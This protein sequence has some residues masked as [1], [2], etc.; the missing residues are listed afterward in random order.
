MSVSAKAM[1]A[2]AFTILVWG[3]IPVFLRNLSLSLGPYDFL[4]VRLILAGIILSYVLATTSDFHM[5][6]RD[7]PRL[8]LIAYAGALGYFA[9][10]TFGY[11]YVTAGVGTLILSTQPMIIALLAWLAG[12]DTLTPRSIIGLVVAFA[13]SGL[14]VYADDATAGA[15]S[16]RDLLIGSALIFV[17][18]T[19]WAIHVVF[20]KSLIQKHGALKITCLVNMLIAPVALP[21]LTPQMFSAVANLKPAAMWSLILLQTLGTAS[22]FTWNYAAGHARPTL[23]GASLYVMPILAFF[24]GWL[25]LDEKITGVVILA[26]FVILTGVTISQWKPTT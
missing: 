20:G 15:V 26:A 1:I 4:V 14:L 19:A 22:V 17:A 16:Q 2:L 18:G 5:P 23:V 10:S 12:T 6:R 24:A 9:L 13:G 7:W 8:A 11:S 21:F 25:F 3:V